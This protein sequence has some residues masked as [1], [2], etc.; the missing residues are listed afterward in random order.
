MI[1]IC[2]LMTNIR[3]TEPGKRR[4]SCAPCR[5]FNALRY[6]LR[7][8]QRR[9]KIRSGAAGPFARLIVRMRIGIR[10]DR[11]AIKMPGCVAQYR[12]HR[13][14][15]QEERDR[16][17]HQQRGDN[18]APQRHGHRIFGD[19]ADR[20]GKRHGGADV[21]IEQQ[22]KRDRPDAERHDGE[23]K[24]DA[25]ADDDQSPACRRGEH[26]PGELADRRRRRVAER[27]DVDRFR[28]HQPEQE[29]CHQQQA[30]R[31]DGAERRRMQHVERAT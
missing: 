1:G 19:H 20:S 30:E 18:E 13:G 9:R 16:P 8:K 15:T 6:R 17:D 31:D 5:R 24:A 7:R 14:Q 21:A 4:V 22:R 3:T 29:D 10:L 28:R 23:Q 27:G 11:T 25:G 2:C 12:H 26:I